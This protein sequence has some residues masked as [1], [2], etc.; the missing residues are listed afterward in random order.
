MPADPRRPAPPTPGGD[1]KIN[2]TTLSAV[3]AVAIGV[4]AGVASGLNWLSSRDSR[5]IATSQL[6]AGAPGVRRAATGGTVPPPAVAS[7]E[8]PSAQANEDTAS[9]RHEETPREPAKPE[10]PAADTG[11]SS[12][13]ELVSRAVDAV[14][15]V[16]TPT[17]R[18]TAFFVAPDTLLTNVHVVGPN[19]SVRLKRTD[20]RIS[21]ARVVALQTAVDIAVLKV[22]P[23]DSNPT[24]LPLGSGERA[25]VGQDVVAIG[26]A[27]G[28]LQNTVTRGIVSALRRSGDA[29]L[30]QTDAAVN[31]GNSGGPLLDR[32]GRV[33]G[34]TTMGYVERQGLNFAVAIEHARPLIEG[35][36]SATSP[37]V[38]PAASNAARAALPAA[39]ADVPGLS[40]AIA[41]ETDQA[42]REGLQAYERTLVLAAREA[43]ALDDYWQRYRASCHVAAP[44]SRGSHEWFALLDASSVAGTAAPACADWLG[45]IRQQAG[46]IDAAVQQAEERARR[47]DVFPGARRDSRRRHRLDF[48]GWDR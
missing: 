39:G 12:I 45:E 44:A 25:R 40:P 22:A 34:I 19:A 14:A 3:V 21:D 7:S 35:R 6:A 29:V 4:I 26:S 28:T 20:G 41:S 8:A 13:E 30:V 5:D 36:L 46:R 2:A 17:S 43:D 42:R 1:Q 47:A 18:G 27:L 32:H 11:E 38:P 9:V 33:I 37:R 15:V 23:P 10:E 16:E 48:D 31:P 24:V